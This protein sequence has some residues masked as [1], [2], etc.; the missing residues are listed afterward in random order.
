MGKDV[1]SGKNSDN[2][3][4]TFNSGRLEGLFYYPIKLYYYIW[5]KKTIL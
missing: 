1:I 2:F 3:G 4:N 5:Q